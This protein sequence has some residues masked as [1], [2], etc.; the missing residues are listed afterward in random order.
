MYSLGYG[1]DAFLTVHYYDANKQEIFMG[2]GLSIIGNLEGV[3]YI[4]F[5]VNVENTGDVPLE[6]SIK[7]ASPSQ[8]KSALPSN[9]ITLTVGEK[10]KWTSDYIDV[11]PFEGTTQIFEVE[12]EGKYTYAGKTHTL[13]KTGQ[14]SLSIQPDPQ[15]GFD[16][17]AV[18]ASGS[19]DEDTEPPETCTESWTCGE[20]GIC[21]NNE[22]IRE[23]TDLNNCG[24]T[25]NM[26]DTVRSCSD[27]TVIFRADDLDY[28]DG[29]VMYKGVGY[30]D[31]GYSAY[32]CDA[33]TAT[34]LLTAPGGNLVCSRSGYDVSDRF[35]IEVGSRGYIYESSDP[36]ALD[37]IT[38]TEPT[39]PY[40]ENGLEIY[41]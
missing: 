15:G 22:Q 35:Y 14:I 2:K 30:G 4:S 8:L 26:P 33:S 17:P 39:S 12:V 32:T 3:E 41:Q 28:K 36:D 11:T 18:L 6:L 9:T 38:T 13:E 16:V 29:W 23:C 5:D 34:V 10:D 19:T 31:V 7:D 24:T 1:Q 40:A 20:W 25:N 37:A 21:T 27:K